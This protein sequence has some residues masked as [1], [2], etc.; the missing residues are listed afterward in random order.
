METLLF[1]SYLTMTT[2]S[3]YANWQHHDFLSLLHACV[4]KP[5]VSFLLDE[6]WYYHYSCHAT[7]TTTP[8][9]AETNSVGAIAGT[10]AINSLVLL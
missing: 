1:P 8:T 7:A 6:Y 10:L 9:D 5:I 2:I 3:A 4:M